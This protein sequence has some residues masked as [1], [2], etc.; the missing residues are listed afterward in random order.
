M[1]MTEFKSIV[2]LD[3]KQD[4]SLSDTHKYAC[5]YTNVRSFHIVG[6]LR[7]WLIGIEVKVLIDGVMVGFNYQLDR[8]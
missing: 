7:K 4:E 1:P 3:Y 2:I 5:P 8:T 6:L